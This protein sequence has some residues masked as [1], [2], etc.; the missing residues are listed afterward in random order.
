MAGFLALC[1]HHQNDE[2]RVHTTTSIEYVPKNKFS[3]RCCLENTYVCIY[4]DALCDLFSLRALGSRCRMLAQTVKF[5]ESKR[6]SAKSVFH[7]IKWPKQRTSRNTE[8]IAFGAHVLSVCTKILYPQYIHYTQMC[9]SLVCALDPKASL[10][11]V[12]TLIFPTDWL[13]GIFDE[14]LRWFSRN[15]YHF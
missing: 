15:S 2:H 13:F 12:D 4:S 10:C 9:F 1:T 11:E 14:D 5:T 3:V 6:E 7:F 8:I